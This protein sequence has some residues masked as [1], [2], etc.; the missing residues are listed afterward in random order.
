M[1][2]KIFTASTNGFCD[3]IIG[4]SFGKVIKFHEQD[5]RV[6]I[7]KTKGVKAFRL[8]EGEVVVGITATNNIHPVSDFLLVVVDEYGNIKRIDI[9]E[10]PITGRAGKGFKI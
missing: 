10:I 3:I 2:D 9:T 4:T 6:T 8:E 5:V 7:R 1:E